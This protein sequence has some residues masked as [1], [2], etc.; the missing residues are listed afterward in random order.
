MKR[1]RA[2]G[3][4]G[5]VAFVAITSP[6]ALADESSWRWYG[7]VNVGQSRAK[8]DDVRITSGLA[9]GRFATTSIADDDRDTG[10][11]LFGGYQVNKYFAVEG[12]YFD[13]GKFGFTASTLPAGTLS[14][15]MKVRGLNLDL[16]G[17]LPIT[18]KFSAFGRV[19]ANYA[20]TQDAFT[21]TGLVHVVNANPSKRETNV[22]YGAGFQYAFTEALALRAEVERYRINDAVGNKGDVDLVS[23][24]LVYRF[25]GNRP[26][27]ASRP[28]APEPVMPVTRTAVPEPVVV[29]TA[30]P[31]AAVIPPPPQPRK[32]TF[33]ADSLFDFDQ[34]TVKATGKQALDKFAA[35]LKGT[36]YDVI[37]VTGYTDRLGSLAY[38]V[39]LSARRAEAVKSYLVEPAGI[40]AGKIAARGKGESDPVT[41]PGE[42]KGQKA[43]RA[44]IDCLQPDRRVEVEVSGT[45]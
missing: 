9:A 24:G 13:L 17:M 22:K 21:G 3:A 34:A 1:A 36:S 29:A 31:P 18:D 16:V 12:G 37:S 27:P 25:G 7:G 6:L 10:Y 43:S 8:I 23:V 28:M 20:H 4:L 2:S 33:S 15:N 30:P 41:K 35:E 44:L 5:L 11:K 26:V 32:V 45:R 39:A 40:P 42:C 19:G 14:G 38:N